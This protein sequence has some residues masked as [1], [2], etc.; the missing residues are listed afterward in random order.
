MP[1]TFEHEEADATPPDGGYGW[2][3]VLALFLVNF[4]TWGAVAVSRSIAGRKPKMSLTPE[5]LKVIWLVSVILLEHTT[6]PRRL[7]TGVRPCRRFQLRIC[8][9][10]SS[11]RHSAYAPIWQGLDHAYWDNSAD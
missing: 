5:R 1:S 8:N 7:G 4:S 6:L 11:L 10:C 3:C 9:D 2:I